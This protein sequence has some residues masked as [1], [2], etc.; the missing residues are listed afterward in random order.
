M[1]QQSI[2]KAGHQNGRNAPS[3]MAIVDEYEAREVALHPFFTRLAQRPVDLGAIWL[4]MA[5]LGQGISGHF[6]NWLAT[7]IS[8]SQDK[9]ISCFLAKQL[10]DELG[11]GDPD[12]IHSILLDRFIAG[13]EPWRPHHTRRDD[14]L[15]PGR[16]L[17]VV[18]AKPF[19]S[20][21]LFDA[22]GALMVGEIFAKKMDHCVGDQ[23]RRQDAISP[24]TLY[25]LTL[26]ETL[27]ID[28]ADDSRDLALLVPD[29]D[30]AQL[31]ARSGAKLQ[32][33]ALW[34][35]LTEVHGLAE[36]SRIVP[37]QADR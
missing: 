37:P 22:I 32:W 7:T 28:H 17:A 25:W 21:H 6:V 4:L 13:L 3:A 15:G 24:A 8:R 20:G 36:G 35:F 1:L 10:N 18:G 26:H 12:Q 31:A 30:A 19:S 9:R 5:N 23:V 27:E 34:D 2:E 11:N 29:D 33:E 14:L 16:K